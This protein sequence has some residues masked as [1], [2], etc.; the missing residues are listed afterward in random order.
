MSPKGRLAASLA[1]LVFF[2][3]ACLV[4]VEKAESKAAAR[5]FEEARRRIEK[6][7]ASRYKVPRRLV[8]LVYQPGEAQLVKVSLPY[9][10]VRKGL[11][12]SPEEE[13]NHRGIKSNYQFEEKALKEAL[14]QMPPGLLVEVWGEEEKI[15]VWLE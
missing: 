3:A 4:Y 9:W 2:S 10:M 15:L 12:C 14:R 6:I 5:K 8:C 7:S 11:L 1:L 13:N